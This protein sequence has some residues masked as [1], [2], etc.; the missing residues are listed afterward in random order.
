[1]LDNYEQKIEKIV[2]KGVEKPLEPK[3]SQ[4]AK[5]MEKKERTVSN[6]NIASSL[7]VHGFPEEVNKTKDENLHQTNETLIELMHELGV[8]TKIE[9]LQ[10]LGK[11]DTT[12]KKTRSVFVKLENQ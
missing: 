3:F 1:M 12:R 6:R 7:R 2:N 4:Q 5:L 9:N 10:R 8:H 11:I